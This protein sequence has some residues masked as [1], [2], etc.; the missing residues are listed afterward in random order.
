MTAIPA[1]VGQQSRGSKCTFTAIRAGDELLIAFSLP[2]GGSASV[3]VAIKAQSFMTTPDNPYYGPFH[4]ET[5]GDRRTAAIK[6]RTADGSD[7][8]MFPNQPLRAH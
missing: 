1:G 4:L 7:S 2:R 5:D 6:L 8:I 3:S